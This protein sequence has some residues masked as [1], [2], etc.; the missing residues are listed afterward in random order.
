M[1]ENLRPLMGKEQMVFEPLIT[2]SQ[3]NG[4]GKSEALI[5]NLIITL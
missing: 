1:V 4:S 5:D 3:L 2:P